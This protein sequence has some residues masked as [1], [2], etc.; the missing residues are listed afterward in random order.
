MVHNVGLSISS[1]Y[2]RRARMAREVAKLKEE[3]DMLKQKDFG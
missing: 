2:C 1:V 3:A